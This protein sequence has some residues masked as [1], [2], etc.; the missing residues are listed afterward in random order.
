MVSSVLN[1]VKMERVHQMNVVPDLLPEIHPSLDL[2]VNFLERLPEKLRK[3]DRT[4]RKFEKVEAG[5]YL[6]PEQVPSLRTR[7]GKFG[8]LTACLDS[9]TGGALHKCLPYG[10]SSLHASYG[11][12]WFVCSFHERALHILIS[13]Q[14]SLIPR[15]NHS[16]A[17][18]TGCSEYTCRLFRVWLLNSARPNVELHTFS[19]NPIPLTTTHTPYIPPHPQRGTPYHRYVIM[20]VPQQNPTER[21]KVPVPT[22]QERLGFDYRAFAATHGLDATK[23]GGIFMW[24]E[25]WDETVSK[26]YA[27]V[28]SA[29]FSVFLGCLFECLCALLQKRRSL[30]SAGCQSQIRMPTS[31]RRRNMLLR[32][33]R[34]RLRTYSYEDYTESHLLT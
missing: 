29:Y 16:R 10:A 5:V 12:P 31:R 3:Q 14:T 8:M 19:K 9:Q 6:L 23:G 22:E 13:L 26:I 17:T 21:I 32:L 20:L 30:S 28:L 15:T 24:R 7:K 4:K 34:F 25:V 11:R 18:F 33:Q 1:I 2:R 27:E